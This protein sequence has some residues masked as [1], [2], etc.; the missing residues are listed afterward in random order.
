MASDSSSIH[1]SERLPYQWFG[2]GIS[3]R[4]TA[5]ETHISRPPLIIYCVRTNRRLHRTRCRKYPQ[6]STA[7]SRAPS[8]ALRWF[9]F[10]QRRGVQ[11]S[12]QM[13]RVFV[14][15]LFLS[16]SSSS[17]DWKPTGSVCFEI[18]Y[19]PAIKAL[20]G[21]HPITA[22]RF[23]TSSSREKILTGKQA[24]RLALKICRDVERRAAGG[25]VRWGGRYADRFC[26]I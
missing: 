10:V 11:Q 17:A 14:V 18:I 24:Q 19:Q 2:Y 15:R 16:C 25:R 7:H 13:K 6:G 1:A 21:S 5:A 9:A 23:A 4:K 26:N 22:G 3:K 20:V 12:V 8:G